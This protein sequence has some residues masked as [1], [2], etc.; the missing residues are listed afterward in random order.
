MTKHFAVLNCKNKSIV[1]CFKDTFLYSFAFC[2]VAIANCEHET[3]YPAST[4]YQHTAVLKFVESSQ[5]QNKLSVVVF[6]FNFFAA[7]H[8]SEA[9]ARRCSVKN[10]FLKISQNS[11]ENTCARV[12][13]LINLQSSPLFIEHLQWLLLTPPLTPDQFLPVFIERLTMQSKC[14]HLPEMNKDVSKLTTLIAQN[15]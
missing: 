4:Q 5:I 8:A 2:S 13:F 1:I 7:Y 3:N 6:F 14:H 12:S 15:I 9:F 11:L 10:V